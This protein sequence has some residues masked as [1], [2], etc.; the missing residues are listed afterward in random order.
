MEARVV[1]VVV[2]E[3]RLIWHTAGLPHAVQHRRVHAEHALRL[4]VRIGQTII[5]DARDHRHVLIDVHLAI[6]DGRLNEDGLAICR[7]DAQTVELIDRALDHTRD[8]GRRRVCFTDLIGA[9]KE[10]PFGVTACL[11]RQ[12]DRL[13]IGEC[14][15]DVGLGNTHDIHDAL[16]NFRQLLPG[17]NSHRRVHT[18]CLVQQGGKRSGG[19][20]LQLQA[21]RARADR[22][23]CRSL[24][25]LA[26]EG[27]HGLHDARFHEGL[28]DRAAGGLLIDGHFNRAGAGARIVIRRRR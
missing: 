4:S 11:R 9:R 13:G 25:E 2:I 21:V 19:A 20:H 16:L 24:L 26:H 17:A 14:R 28:T 1:W 27:T 22:H 15:I 23:G 3:V 12:A 10:P 6:H 18:V 8:E 5:D 7:G